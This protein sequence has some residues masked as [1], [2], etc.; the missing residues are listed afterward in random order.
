MGKQS[1]FSHCWRWVTVAQD[2][3][4]LKR[5]EFREAGTGVQM[6][7]VM[8]PAAAPLSVSSTRKLCVCVGGFPVWPPGSRL[9]SRASSSP[10]CLPCP[11][12]QGDGPKASVS[13]VCAQ[14][15]P[16]AHC[17]KHPIPQWRTLKLSG[18]CLSCSFCSSLKILI[19][20][21]TEEYWLLAGP[22]LPESHLNR[23]SRDCKAVRRWGLIN[24]PNSLRLATSKVLI[25]WSLQAHRKLRTLCCT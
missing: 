13:Q 10:M 24:F 1:Q 9:S 16:T 25:L 8:G 12:I 6:R 14:H 7:T 5:G 15:L 19:C 23:P 2:R 17:E 21:Q 18:R 22:L 4:D 20:L 3:R 11:L